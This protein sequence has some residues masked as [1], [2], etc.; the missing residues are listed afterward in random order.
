MMA[1]ENRLKGGYIGRVNSWD[2]KLRGGLLEFVISNYLGNE[3]MRHDNETEI[4]IS[5]QY[6]TIPI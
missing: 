4:G 2:V 1:D 5:S 6:D 3:F